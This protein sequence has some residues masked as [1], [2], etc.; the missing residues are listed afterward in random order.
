M[1]KCVIT[2]RTAAGRHKPIYGQFKSTGEATCQMYAAMNGLCC[3]KV[4]V[5]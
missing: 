5:L 1:I 3:V 4:K 2:I